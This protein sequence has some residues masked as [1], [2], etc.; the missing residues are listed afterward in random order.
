VR[1]AIKAKE[2]DLAHRPASNLVFLI[3]VSGSMESPEKLPLVKEALRMLINHLDGRDR[4]SIVV[5]AGASGLVIAPTRCSEKQVLI[6]AI[7]RLG[8]GGGTNGGAGIELAYKTA[9]EHFDPNGSNRVILATDGDFNLGVTSQGDLIRMVE[10][11]AKQGV[12]LTVLGFGMGNYK[13]STLEKLADKGN[14]NYAYVD[15]LREANKVLIEQLTGTL[16]TLAK[17][18][19]I[20]VEFNPTQVLAYRLIGY[21]NRLLADEDFNDDKKDAGEIGA[22]LSVTAL[23]EIAAGGSDVE[24][25]TVDPLKYQKPAEIAQPTS[26]ELLTVKLRYK[27][28]AEDNSQLLEFPLEDNN[29]QFDAA[30]PDFRFAAAVASFGMLLR[31]SPHKGTSSYR[32]VISIARQTIGDDPGGYRTDFIRL[33]QTAEALQRVGR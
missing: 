4:I 18:V 27:E 22:G 30:S 31:D 21:E 9:L 20:Q 2:I 6:D 24:L 3:D 15:T 16:L 12:F 28:P 7:G 8:A 26:A 11:R 29:R 1:I 10:E 17:D 23:Y 19:K 13:D 32:G 25:S 5:Y 14:G 33:A